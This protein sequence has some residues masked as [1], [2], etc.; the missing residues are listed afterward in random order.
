MKRYFVA[1]A[2]L[3]DDFSICLNKDVVLAVRIAVPRVFTGNTVTS[4]ADLTFI[5][6]GSGLRIRSDATPPA[7]VFLTA[8]RVA[9]PMVEKMGTDKSCHGATRNSFTINLSWRVE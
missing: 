1:L 5:D 7:P 8:R 9:T 2:A 6:T 4:G 3:A